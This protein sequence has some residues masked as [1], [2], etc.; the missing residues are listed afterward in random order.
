MKRTL[1]S[2]VKSASN[3]RVS[4]DSRVGDALKGEVPAFALQWQDLG[5]NRPSEGRQLINS[6]LSDALAVKTQFTEKEWDAFC[7][8]GPR[9][10]DF[11]K[12]GDSYFQP[13]KSPDEVVQEDQK[14]KAGKAERGNQK[15][16]KSP[17]KSPVKSLKSMAPTRQPPVSA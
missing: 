3:T 2:V 12:V 10:D 17:G 8:P 4:P 16:G 14:Q 1:I 11:I 13:G 6:R 7:M 9:I 15:K 5:P